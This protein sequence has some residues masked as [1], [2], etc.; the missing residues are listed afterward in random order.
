MTEAEQH[1]VSGPDLATKF[2][3]ALRTTK[4][5]KKKKKKK[6]HPRIALGDDGAANAS[7]LPAGDCGDC[8]VFP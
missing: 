6:K 1:D 4:R 3:S 2:C 5:K 7:R 8:D